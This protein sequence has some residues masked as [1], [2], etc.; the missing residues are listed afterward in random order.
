M[1][2]NDRN[3]Q[4]L[5]ALILFTAR[6]EDVVCFYRAIGIPLES[7]QHEAGPIHFACEFGRTHFAVFE[8]GDGR[9]PEFRSG[10]SCFAGF[11]VASI[12]KAISAARV[13][14]AEIIQEPESYPWGVRALVQDPDGR[15]VE[16]FERAS[17]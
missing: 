13:I 8:A 3:V 14:G 6:I 2:E 7:E 9:A 12:E 10:G 5:G 15:V 1:A 4:D 17:T 11:A 16:L